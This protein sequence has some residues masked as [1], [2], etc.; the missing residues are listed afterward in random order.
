MEGEDQPPIVF[1]H[2]LPFDHRIWTHQIF[3]FSFNHKVFGLDF[4]DLG[5]YKLGSGPC[6]IF[7][8]SDDLNNMMKTEGID[9]AVIVGLSLG[10]AVAQR[11]AL[12]YPEKVSTLILAGTSCSYRADEIQKKFSD[13]VLQYQSADAR[14]HYANN[15]KILFSSRFVESEQEKSIL[16]NYTSVGAIFCPVRA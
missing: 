3:E 10:G 13:R 1:L 12:K 8:L 16:R 6:T 11:F 7:S 4:P 14:E 5:H 2:P 15:L 9:Q